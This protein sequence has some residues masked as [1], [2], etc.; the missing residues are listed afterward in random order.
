MI[1]TLVEQRFNRNMWELS[2][3]K[4]DPGLHWVGKLAGWEDA[5]EQLP[6]H[7]VSGRWTL[8]V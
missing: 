6:C 7:H 8:F 1:R 3:K 4:K 2:K 5:A